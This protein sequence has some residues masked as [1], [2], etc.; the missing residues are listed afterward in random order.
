[1]YYEL[2]QA[3]DYY[4]REF[5]VII[6]KEKNP[7]NVDD[8]FYCCTVEKEFDFNEEQYNTAV[9]C[10]ENCIDEW[11]VGCITSAFKDEKDAMA[12]KLRWA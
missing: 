12:F 6:S 7:V 4:I 2:N 3:G 10:E 9:W 1:M 11:L 5:Y 8:K